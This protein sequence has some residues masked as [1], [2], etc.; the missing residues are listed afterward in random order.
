MVLACGLIIVLTGFA[1]LAFDIGHIVIVR[2]ELQN[3][4]DSSA[5]AG[6]NCLDKEIDPASTTNCISTPA[7]TL[8]WS[9]ATAKAENQLSHNMAAN[10]PVSSTGTG[11]VVEVGYW[12]LLTNSPSGGSFSTTFGPLTAY[13]KPAIKMTVTKDTGMNGGPITMLTAAMFG[14]SNVPMSASAVAVLSS[15]SFVLPGN[16]IP[17]VINECMYE[18]FWDSATNTPVIYDGDPV[19]P[20]GISVIGQPWEVRIGSGYHYDTCAAGQWTSFKLDKN[21]ANTTGDLIENGNPSSLAIGDEVWI[22]PGTQTASFKDLDNQ[23]PTPPGADLT[24]LVVDTTDLTNKGEAEIVGFGGFRITDVKGGGGPNES[25]YIQGRFIPSITTSG[26]SG[27][28]PSY[29]TYTPPR[30]A[31]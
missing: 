20:Y 18:R 25:K 27:I 5:L 16:V 17:L 7:G 14:G 12:N 2:N 30:L 11:H 1:V 13:D 24:V 21:D 28:G 9:R 15:P 22:Q 10:L 4:A 31:Q 23:F 6:A 8:N 29:G 26:S 19:D 3:V